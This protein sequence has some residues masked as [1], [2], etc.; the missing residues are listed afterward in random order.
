M[1]R[2]M[3]QTSEAR[4]RVLDAA[5]DLFVQHGISGTS[6]QMIADRIGVTKAAVYHQF[7][8]KGD[9][10]LGL[11]E[12]VFVSLDSLVDAVEARPDVERSDVVITG[13]VE[14]M[15]E[16]RQVMSALY[17]DPEMER[18]VTEHRELSA[19]RERLDRLL[20]PPDLVD[21]KR[22]R[23]EWAVVGAGFTRAIVDPQFADFSDEDLKNELIRLAHRILD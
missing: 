20:T 23:L 1:G 8:A 10:A 19:T 22:R 6:L 7:P 11:L 13:I 15:V 4:K 18:L 9:I 3:G 21:G 16:Q 14:I 17:R 5:L 12:S 2:P